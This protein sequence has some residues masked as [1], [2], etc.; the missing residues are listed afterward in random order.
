MTRRRDWAL[1]VALCLLALLRVFDT[2]RTLSP[3]TDE[4]AQLAAGMEWIE[5]GT[6]RYDPQHPPGRAVFAAAARVV[7]A[8]HCGAAGMGDEGRR[9]L[10][11]TGDHRQV[12]M[13]ARLAAMPFFIGS[14][15]LVFF[16][17]RSVGGAQSAFFAVLGY[18]TVP[19]V[20]A[21]SGL[22]TTDP[23]V[24]FSFPLALGC[25]AMWL[26]QPSRPA[27]ARF[28]VA[29]ALVTLS[30]F[31]G[32]LFLLSVITPTS[33]L[34]LG[35]KLC[36]GSA[37]L[38]PACRLKL[39]LHH[40]LLVVAP[41]AFLLVWSG[42]RFSVQTGSGLPIPAPDFCLGIRTLLDHARGGH[43]SYFLGDIQLHG[44]PAFFPVGLLIKVPIPFLMLSLAGLLVLAQRRTAL[45]RVAAAAPV[46]ILLVCLPSTINIGMRHVLPAFPLLAVAFGAACAELLRRKAA[47]RLV[48]ASLLA[49]QLTVSA[50]AHP[51]YLPYFNE[52]AADAPHE[53]LSDSDL[54]WGQDLD[55]L[56][57]EL[58]RRGVPEVHLAY[59]GEADLRYHGLPPYRQLQPHQPVKGWVAVSLYRLALGTGQP[60]FDEY[61]WV[62]Q[63]EPVAMVG[64]SIVLYHIR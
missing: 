27:A 23:L 30:K 63:H 2:Y 34:W 13:A 16:W 56:A 49:W 59:F 47:A 5:R 61:R 58:R 26:E 42:Y 8:R 10:Y 35:G 51:D 21:H 22:A 52:I 18:S 57:Q 50:R 55:R 7:G 24:T 46:M 64:K 41:L 44:R 60:P 20:L 62:L 48:L 38:Q 29:L 14:L 1:L 43:Y 32:L 17:A 39:F 12:L 11:C 3:T 9:V 53:W 33:L 28:G 40:S 19:L 54:D 31:S 37:P 36:A 6:C 15:L 45:A 4:P 25:W